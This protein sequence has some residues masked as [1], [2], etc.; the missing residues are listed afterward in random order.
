M[1]FIDLID[2]FLVAV[3]MY[4]LY[5][6]TKGTVAVNILIGLFSFIGFWFIVKALNMELLGGILDTLVS[7]G[8]IALIVLFQQEIR[9]FLL[10]IGSRYNVSSWFAL[11]KVLVKNKAGMLKIYVKPIVKACMN[12]SRTK[13]GALII[14]S[15]SSDLLDI[16]KTGELLNSVISSAVLESI[17]FKNSPLHDGA[18]IIS[19][20]KVKAARCILPISHNTDLPDELGLRHRAGLGIAQSTDAQVVIVSEESGNV[21]YAHKG[22]LVHDITFDDLTSY[23]AND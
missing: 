5:K 19:Q 14:I 10:L 1:R 16:T 12:M 2:I 21:S 4:Q 8:A 15:K 3:L 18:V 7:V 17:F 9:K 13:T 23:L 11:D 6:I 20:N 22:K